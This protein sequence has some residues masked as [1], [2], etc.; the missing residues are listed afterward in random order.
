MKV[1]I[2]KGPHTD[3][4]IQRCYHYILKMYRKEMQMKRDSNILPREHG[5]TNKRLQRRRTD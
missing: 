3:E 5:G 1:K 4:N 2:I